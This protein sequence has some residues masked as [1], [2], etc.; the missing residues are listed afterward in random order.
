MAATFGMI[1]TV[2]IFMIRTVATF[3]P[4]PDLIFARVTSSLYLLSYVA[5][6][7][8][9]GVFLAEAVDKTKPRL[10]IGA[11][12]SLVGCVAAA[13]IVALNLFI[14][15]DRPIVFSPSLGVASTI[16]S[17][18]L[19]VTSALFF[20]GFLADSRSTPPRELTAARLALVGALLS[21]AAHGAAAFIFGPTPGSS[22]EV[23]LLP[24]AVGTP[25][26]LFAVG[27]WLFFLWVIARRQA[28]TR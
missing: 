19:P 26:I 12:V 3:N 13:A 18:L 10:K 23:S 7:V 8:F 14:L 5:I 9:F 24:M 28:P 11:W 16:A 1:G 22:A 15:F 4:S 6:I 21:A 17:M 25:I 20:A 2:L 27:T